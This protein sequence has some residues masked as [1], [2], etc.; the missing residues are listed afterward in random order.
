MYFRSL[1]F[2]PLD[3]DNP[4]LQVGF[5]DKLPLN[6][7]DRVAQMLKPRV[8]QPRSRRCRIPR[9]AKAGV[10]GLSAANGSETVAAEKADTVTTEVSSSLPEMNI[11]TSEPAP[12]MNDDQDNNSDS[13]NSD[14]YSTDGED[15]K[16]VNATPAANTVEAEPPKPTPMQLLLLS[17]GA[18]RTWRREPVKQ[19]PAKTMVRTSGFAGGNS[20]GFSFS[21]EN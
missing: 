15:A 2:K 6:V 14:E 19:A 4:I 8:V 10:N 16:E 13:E 11:S 1:S 20:G 3:P 9:T 21:T 7:A 12:A 5:D 18:R 17:H